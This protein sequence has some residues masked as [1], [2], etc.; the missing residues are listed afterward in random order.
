V[1][2]GGK[3]VGAYLGARATGVGDRQAGALATLMNTRG[4]TELVILNVGFTLGVL[5]PKLFTLM[6][7]MAILTTSMTGPLLKAVYPNRLIERD[8]A[9]AERAALSATAAYRVMVVVNSLGDTSLVDTA[10]DLAASCAPAE[11]LLTRLVVQR[12]TDRLEIGSGIGEELL[13]MTQ[14]LSELHTLGARGAGRGV[15]TPAHAQFSEDLTR[16][17]TRVIIGAE[18]DVL[19]LDNDT[20]PAPHDFMPRVI[21]QRIAPPPDATEVTVLVG[22]RAADTAA[23][24]QA[25]AQLAVGRGLGM[26]LVGARGRCDRMV[27]ELRRHGIDAAVGEVTTTSIV[28]SGAEDPGIHLLARARPDDEATSIDD[29]AGSLITMR[30]VAGGSR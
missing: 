23:A 25:G 26:V 29:W 30:P 28:V 12:K 7:I 4:L 11:V 6:V 13:V 8:I 27:A 17:L 19:V 18:P 24:L 14:T 20:E 3:F 15:T 16:D 5:D 21:R 1:A 10:I 2:I 22:G 9:D